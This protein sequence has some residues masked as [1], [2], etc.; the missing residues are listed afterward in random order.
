MS[1]PAEGEETKAA[2]IIIKRHSGDHDGGHHGS[3]W[4]I[5]YADFVTAMMA[6]FLVMWLINSSDKK[7]L[8]QVA[9]YFNPLRLTDKS[10]ASKGLHEAHSVEQT[11]QGDEV[12]SSGSTQGAQAE[13]NKKESKGDPK[14]KFSDDAIFQDPLS[15]L[16]RM[17]QEAKESQ[18][19]QPKPSPSQSEPSSTVSSDLIRDPFDPGFRQQVEVVRKGE[20]GEG[21]GAKNEKADGGHAGDLPDKSKQ[22]GINEGESSTKAGIGD[23]AEKKLGGGDAEARKQANTPPQQPAP[24]DAAKAKAT[25]PDKSD[26]PEENPEAANARVVAKVAQLEREVKATI[27]QVLS[28]AV[29]NIEVSNTD[30]GILISITDDLDFGMFALGSAEPQPNLVLVMEKLGEVLAKQSEPVVVRGHTDSRP[31][32]GERY[33]NWRLSTARAHMA[34]YMLLRGGV[35]EKR[36]EKVEGYADK[37]L[38]DKRDPMAAPNRRIEILLRRTK[39]S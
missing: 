3:A 2:E 16:D 7:T 15:M 12:Q 14:G 27:E 1:H 23:I 38:R 32:K 6:F 21:T 26:K 28:G 39:A 35:D 34:Y 17:A 30:E 5:A 31:F 22:G 8:T 24:A 37:R 9:T 10:A 13:K 29:P 36:F 33:D 11:S 4:K 20:K 25:T 19:A 18:A